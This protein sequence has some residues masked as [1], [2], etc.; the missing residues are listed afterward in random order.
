M[1][2]RGAKDPDAVLL[3]GIVIRVVRTRNLPVGG[4]DLMLTSA[5]LAIMIIFVQDIT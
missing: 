1:T 4:D 3:G 5:F 2:R